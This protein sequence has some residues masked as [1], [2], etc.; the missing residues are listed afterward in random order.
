MPLAPSTPTGVRST[1]LSTPTGVRSTT[2]GTPTGVRSTTPG[3]PTGAGLIDARLRPADMPEPLP[4]LRAAD[5]PPGALPR[6]LRRGTIARVGAGVYVPRAD[7]QLEDWQIRFLESEALILA[8]GSTIRSGTTIV[9]DHAALLLGADF[10]TMPSKVHLA[11]PCRISSLDRSPLAERHHQV[12]GREHL[13]TAAGLPVTD[14]ART[15]VDCARHAGLDQGMTI[16]SSLMRIT[17]APDPRERAAGEARGAAFTGSMLGIIEA[18]SGH[19]GN[20]RARMVAGLSS[21]WLESPLEVRSYLNVLMLGLPAPTLQK[22]F[23]IGGKRYFADAAW[24]GIDPGGRPWSVILESDGYI[25]Y[26]DRSYWV[27]ERERDNDL[28]STGA[29]VIHVSWEIAMDLD[30]FAHTLLGAFPPHVLRTLR[31]H[32]ELRRHWRR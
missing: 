12:I 3:T 19:R 23:V 22:M 4:L 9:R 32:S 17:T 29:I 2:P 14:H 1:T 16:A 13:L 30:K 20:R 10:L 31:P 26:R 27:R 28:R 7:P 11:T 24:E 5:F 18:E 6:E 15:A 25:K 21:G 8:Q